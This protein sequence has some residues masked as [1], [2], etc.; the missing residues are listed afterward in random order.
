MPREQ[1]SA[2]K[3]ERKS[4]HE[5]NGTFLLWISYM[6]VSKQATIHKFGWYSK[7]DKK[8]PPEKTKKKSPSAHLLLGGREGGLSGLKGA[9][10][11]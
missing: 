11:L 8:A 2:R 4:S 7:N 6:Y 9:S 3:L 10:S 1:I 5:S